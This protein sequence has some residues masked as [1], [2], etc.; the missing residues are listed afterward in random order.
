MSSRGIF[1]K[2][3][4]IRFSHCDP[5]GIV[6]YPR[7]LVLTQWLVEDW[8]NEALGIGF[9]DFIGRRSLGLPVATLR[10]D[11]VEPAR[12]GDALCLRL[13]VLRLGRRSFTVSIEGE[14]GGR[15]KLRAEQVLVTTSLAT[16]RAID[17]PDDLRAAV[18]RFGVA[19]SPQARQGRAADSVC[20]S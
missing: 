13:S 7:Y 18:E 12:Q 15:L 20:L 19:G 11:F 3:A 17:I 16:E 10:Y 1:E 6:Y 4:P 2:T 9:A 5:A 14:V 8:F